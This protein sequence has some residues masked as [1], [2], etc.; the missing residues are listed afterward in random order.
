MHDVEACMIIVTV[1]DILAA[2][3]FVNFSDQNPNFTPLFADIYLESDP[4]KNFDETRLLHTRSHYCT[5][6]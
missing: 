6:L 4:D 3:L 5:L 1:S 2:I